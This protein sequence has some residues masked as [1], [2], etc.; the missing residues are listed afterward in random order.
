MS[1][2]KA[3]LNGK[4]VK[5]EDKVAYYGVPSND[6]VTFTRMQ[7]FT[8]FGKSKNPN[9]YSRRYV[10]E[11][12]ERTSVTGYSS[13]MS[14]AFDQYE[15]NAVHE[16][17]VNMADNEITGTDAVRD[18]VIVDFSK[19]LDAES[20]KYSARKRSFSVIFDTEGDE[21]AAYT[22]SGNFRT[23]SEIVSGAATVA[24]DGLTLTFEKTAADE[25][26]DDDGGNG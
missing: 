1:G 4:L 13:S 9:E 2:I 10:D 7:G 15:D 18:I 11:G 6:G 5:R 14:F 12:F 17:M 20:R 8:S 19:P 25:N 21:T 23:E 16:D 26:N 3:E 22:Y 24:A